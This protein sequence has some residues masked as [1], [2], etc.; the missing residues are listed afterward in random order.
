[1]IKVPPAHPQNNGVNPFSIPSGISVS[2]APTNPKI[3]IDTNTNPIISSNFA[4]FLSSILWN[5]KD[6]WFCKTGSVWISILQFF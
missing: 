3:I 5:Q 2:N 4:I 6:I 1:M